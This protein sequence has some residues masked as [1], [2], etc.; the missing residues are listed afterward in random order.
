M[1][2]QQMK[3]AGGEPGNEQQ[4]KR[5]DREDTG[6]GRG[7]RRSGVNQGRHGNRKTQGSEKGDKA[8]SRR[9]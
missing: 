4:Q 9:K 5:R 1:A 6:H 3:Q 7:T 2:K 8:R